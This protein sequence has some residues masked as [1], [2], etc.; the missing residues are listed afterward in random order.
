MRGCV[1]CKY[2]GVW[3]L[4]ELLVLMFLYGFFVRRKGGQCDCGKLWGG[5]EGRLTGRGSLNF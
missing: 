1:R 3:S 5:Q 2:Q 4:G